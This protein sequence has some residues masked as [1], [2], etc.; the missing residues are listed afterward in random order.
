MVMGGSSY[1][2]HNLSGGRLQ[3]CRSTTIFR[4]AAQNSSVEDKGRGT[5]LESDTKG[6]F[7]RALQCRTPTSATTKVHLRV[8]TLPINLLNF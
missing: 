8:F 1:T 7:G 5:E 6:T 2:R 3:H 4:K